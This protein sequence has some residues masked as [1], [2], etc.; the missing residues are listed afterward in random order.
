MTLNITIVSAGAVYQS[1]DFRLSVPDPGSRSYKEYKNIAHKHFTFVRP[2]WT[3]LVAF[4][5]IGVMPSFDVDAWLA[6]KERELAST[7]T[8][9]DLI[10]LLSGA[11]QWLRKITDA[12]RSHT[13]TLAGFLGRQPFASL[14]S[15]YQTVTGQSVL[16]PHKKLVLSTIRPRRPK[17]VLSGRVDSVTGADRKRLLA[18]ARQQT[19]RQAML[20]L[21]AQINVNAAHHPSSLGA[22]G[23]ACWTSYLSRDGKSYG[24]L[25]GSIR[26]GDDSL[27]PS[28]RKLLSSI[29]PGQLPDLFD[30]RGNLRSSLRIVQELSVDRPDN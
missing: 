20:A 10:E 7:A 27:S 2:G 8:Y 14:L 15:T 29:G 21:L 5:G 18:A 9:E 22:V 23:E 28:A 12:E 6:R 26:D 17:L 13:F 1:A 11:N 19:E 4:S 25:H 16:T 24:E 30:E 3:A